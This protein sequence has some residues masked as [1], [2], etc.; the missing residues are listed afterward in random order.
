MHD[1]SDVIFRSAGQGQIAASLSPSPSPALWDTLCM[2]SPEVQ[3][4][5]EKDEERNK[6]VEEGW[7]NID[8]EKNW[9]CIES[10]SG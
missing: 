10:L 8:I 5:R 9:G 7:K 1:L 6:S 4:L 2:T 3:Y